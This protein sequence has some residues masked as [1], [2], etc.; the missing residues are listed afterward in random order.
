MLALALAAVLAAAG[1][2]NVPE[3]F[4]DELTRA[5]ERTELAIRLPETMPSDLAEHHPRAV[6]RRRSYRLQI[7]G[8]ADCRGANACLIAE[9][10]GRRG[11]APFGEEPVRLRGGRTGRFTRLSCGASCSPPMIEWRQGRTT[12]SILA[13]VGSPRTQ[14]RIL[15]R[16]ANSAILHGPR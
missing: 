9:F 10:A 15:V 8:V 1:D 3:L 16:M 6:V 12:Y 13:K 14:R 7:G 4:A 5:R 11:S 2:V